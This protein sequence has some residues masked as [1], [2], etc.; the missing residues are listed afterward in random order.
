MFML[1]YIDLL[2]ERKCF[3]YWCQCSNAA[4]WVRDS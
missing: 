4:C 2:S 3:H 1:I